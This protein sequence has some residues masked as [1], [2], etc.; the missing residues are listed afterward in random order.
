MHASGADEAAEISF[1]E[2]RYALMNLGKRIGM[3]LNEMLQTCLEIAQ[4]HRL[5]N[6][7][8]AGARPAA[9]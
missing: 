4:L 2:F 6:F 5:F 7:Y 3:Q 9:M 1:T 8:A